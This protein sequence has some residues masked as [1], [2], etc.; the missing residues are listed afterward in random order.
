MGISYLAIE[1]R[2]IDIDIDM[3]IDPLVQHSLVQSDH[4][5]EDDKRY[6]ESN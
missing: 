1:D 3:D 2:N 4:L 6:Y 5:S